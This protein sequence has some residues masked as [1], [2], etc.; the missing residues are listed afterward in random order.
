MSESENTSQS[1]PEIDA[2]PSHQPTPGLYGWITHTDLSSLD[3][4]ATRRWCAEALGW[5][6]MPSFPSPNGPYHLFRYSESGGGGIRGVTRPEETGSLP[7]VHVADT[8]AAYEKALNAG[9]E[10]VQPPERVMDGVSIAIV[11]A[12]GGVQIGLSG[13]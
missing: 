5:S 8:R 6:F 3:P 1:A 9:A 4:E 7:F 13:P 12:P 2:P 11:R 10:S